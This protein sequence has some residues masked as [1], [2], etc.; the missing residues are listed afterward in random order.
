MSAYSDDGFPT[1][2]AELGLLRAA[3]DAQVPVL[4]VCLGAQLLAVAAG[5]SARPGLA[6]DSRWDGRP[7]GW[8]PPLPGTRCSPGSRSDCGC[9]T[10]TVTPWIR[11]PG[12]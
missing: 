10:G 5:G 2:T 3:L 12:R 11:P 9:C 7:C 4:G 1:R 8:R 6:T